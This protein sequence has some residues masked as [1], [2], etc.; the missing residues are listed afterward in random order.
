MNIGIITL[1][2]CSNYGQNLQVYALQRFLRDAGHNAFLIRYPLIEYHYNDPVKWLKLS[3]KEALPP[4]LLYLYY[5]LKGKKI[6]LLSVK[7]NL[8]SYKMKSVSPFRTFYR[9]SSYLIHLRAIGQFLDDQINQSALFYPSIIDLKAFPPE[10]DV[11]ITGSDQVWNFWGQPLESAKHETLDAFF[12]NF[13]KPD[14]KRISYAASF[15]TRTI[16]KD[17]AEIIKPLINKFSYVSVRE[18]STLA[19]CEACG[20]RNAEWVPDPTLLLD[21]NHYRSLYVKSQVKKPDKPYCLI[22]M[23]RD[24]FDFLQKAYSWAK[25][26]NLEVCLIANTGLIQHI[27]RETFATIPE[28]LCLIDNAEYV[29]TDSYH[30][31]IFSIIFGKAFGI[32]PFDGCNKDIRLNDLFTRFNLRFPVLDDDK[33]ISFILNDE[34]KA[35][36][37][38]LNGIYKKYTF[39]WFNTILSIKK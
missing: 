23:I 10:A 9:D 21:M 6:S 36:S 33:F 32:I 17:S 1:W 3:I 19:L 25:I 18:K 16:D 38:I 13:G 37:F 8:D 34:I 35:A 4:V 39:D 22:Y 7:K 26:K 5:K 31:S 20:Y 11:Y 29:I 30:G 15:G 27:Y 2:G 14:V 24:N 28:W 12:L